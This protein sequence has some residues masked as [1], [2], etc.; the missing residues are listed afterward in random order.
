MRVL[1]QGADA[2]L[3]IMAVWTA[4]AVFVG[5]ALMLLDDWRW[6]RK[7]P[8]PEEGS[9]PLAR[10]PTPDAPIHRRVATREPLC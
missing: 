1:A 9:A 2:A 4:F 7:T 3:W 5:G 10:P 8:V 6:R